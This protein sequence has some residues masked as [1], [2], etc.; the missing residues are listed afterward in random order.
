MDQVAKLLKSDDTY[1]KIPI[2]MLTARA[3]K[4]DIKRGLALGV[5]EYVTKPFDTENLT[6]LVMQYIK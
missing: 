4:A 5:D 1:K 6:K 3:Q 2:I